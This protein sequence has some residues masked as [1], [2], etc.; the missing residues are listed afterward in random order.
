MTTSTRTD[1]IVR[2]DLDDPGTVVITDMI[3]RSDHQDLGDLIMT[4]RP[5]HPLHLPLPTF[6]PDPPGGRPGQGLAALCSS[7]STFQSGADLTSTDI[8][9]RTGED[10]EVD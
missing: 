1:L 7:D 5:I 4:I 9:I 8:E 2:R 3:E 6:V 10:S